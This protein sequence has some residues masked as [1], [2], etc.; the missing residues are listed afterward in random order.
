MPRIIQI[1]KLL[2][3]H[4]FLLLFFFLGDVALVFGQ[5]IELHLSY[6][7][8]D[9][10]LSDHR[11]RRVLE[12]SNGFIYLATWNGFNRFDGYRCV[13]IDMPKQECEQ[14]VFRENYVYE[15]HEMKNGNILIV[16]KDPEE[17]NCPALIYNPE[18][19]TFQSTILETN[20]DDKN[21][22]TIEGEKFGTIPKEWTLGLTMRNVLE[23]EFGNRL[24]WNNSRANPYAKLQLKGEQE[25]DLSYLF[26]DLLE[27]GPVPF[28]KDLSDNIYL[29]SHIGLFK[30]DV[31]Q[32]SIKSYMSEDMPKW[33]YGISG[34]AILKLPDGRML[35]G[36]DYGALFT[37]VNDSSEAVPLIATN[38]RN[39]KK[40]SI[41]EVRGIHFVDDQNVV[42]VELQGG[43]KRYNT[44]DNTFEDIQPLSKPNVRASTK[45]QC[46]TLLNDSILCISN[47]DELVTFDLK[48]NRIVETPKINGF[49]R[50]F[51]RY[52]SIIQAS[53]DETLWYGTVSGLFRFNPLKDEIIEFFTDGNATL[54]DAFDDFVVYRTLPV[55]AVYDVYEDSDST[56]ILAT[57]GGGIAK[58]DRKSATVENWTVE[59]GLAD[60]TCCTIEKGAEGYWIGTYN[61]LSYWDEK[62]NEFTNFYMENG[63]PHD[64]MNRHSS[65]NAGNGD[66]YFGG[67]NGVFRFNEQELLKP[68]DSCR[69]LISSF[70]YFD[71]TGKHEQ[72]DLTVNS[73][74]SFDI[75]PNSRSF[76]VDLG[77]DDHYNT[78]GHRYYYKLLNED[79]KSEEIEW[80]GLGPQSTLRF[81]FLD[82]GSYTLAFK[83]I[84]AKGNPG[85]DISLRLNVHE[86]FY[87]TAWFALLVILG[88]IGTLYLFYRYRLQQLLRVE[89]LKN[90]LSNDLHDDVGSVLSGIA[91]QMD[92]LNYTV[93]DE[94]KPQ[95]EKV[96]DSS[97]K[98]MSQ[99]RDVVWAVNSES[100]SIQGL[101]ER[102]KEFSSESLDNLNIACHFEV[103]GLD[104]NKE[105]SS[106]VKHSMLLIFKEFSANTIKHSGAQNIWVSLMQSGAGITMVL[107]DDG[108]GFDLSEENRSSGLGLK[109]MEKRAEKINA[110][111]SISG[112]NGV[113]LKLKVPKV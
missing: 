4:L 53:H 77:L 88:V 1:A 42:L 66:F 26:K 30:I 19:G 112:A 52:T 47:Y 48:N 57:Y 99:L 86:F 106:E 90:Q 7:G 58:L 109:S 69:T 2:R 11:V 79:Q 24:T 8:K 37:T 103:K 95:V 70:T 89:R 36:T 15:L 55:Q 92:L 108:V 110:E 67:M 62:S 23:D 113:T 44:V 17:E 29:A 41:G 91:F 75:P 78:T 81:E 13:E 97:R 35:F 16:R 93:E 64:E 100:S 74:D 3:L 22:L 60:N 46:S 63:L 5:N 32:K 10:G 25:F 61:G 54:N 38:K 84:S 104:V 14:T 43:V 82:A 50:D 51:G 49:L 71:P 65:F 18:D 20:E 39:G 33:E 27:V 31:E 101:I 73:G 56:A 21:S 9:E 111:L 28:A 94:H 80:E 40:G 87:K 96:A 6:F 45:Y 107:K 59:D 85:K 34:R 72:I 102:M 68:R 105:L 98:A 83:G 12:H 76:T